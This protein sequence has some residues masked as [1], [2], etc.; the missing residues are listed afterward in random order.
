MSTATLTRPEAPAT[1][2]RFRWAPLLVVLAGTF[3]TF[4]DFFIV[5]VALDSI[6]AQLHAGAGT[7]QLIVAGYALSFAVGMISGGR[8]GDLYGRRRMFSIGL[9]LFTL[10]LALAAGNRFRLTPGLGSVLARGENSRE[11]LQRLR[12]SVVTETL[13]GAVMLAVVAVMG[14]LAPPSAM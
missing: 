7:V 14:T 11:A 8:L 2:E 1:D 4:L 10:M 9:A 3:V 12:R 5:N 13:V 6:G